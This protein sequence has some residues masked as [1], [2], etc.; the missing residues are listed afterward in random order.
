MSRF[1][2]TRNQ[3]GFTLIELL[4]VIAIIAILIG[5]LLP[6]IQKVRD[7][8][9]KAASSNNLKQMTLATVNY[10]D[11]ND[12]SLP[13]YTNQ[14]SIPIGTPPAATVQIFSAFYA[15]LP[16][17]DN[18][19][20]Y[21]QG[22]TTAS[23][24]P[25]RPYFAPGDPMADPRATPGR[26]SYIS[27]SMVLTAVDLVTVPNVS[28]ARF[29]ASITDGPSQTIAFLEAYAVTG[30]NI[31]AWADGAA[32]S[33]NYYAVFPSGQAAS[34]AYA[35]PYTGGGTGGAFFEVTPVHTSTQS[36]ASQGV[37]QGFLS[38]GSQVS[39]FDGS[40]RNCLPALSTSG[41]FAEALTPA[42]GV[43]LGSDW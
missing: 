20:L 13:G 27:N 22:V 7:A 4:V 16:Q 33:Y 31:R 39:L 35:M 15:I 30:T 8:A 18:D 32:T 19:P 28:P 37:S 41:T 21:K 9:N 40:A 2:R 5:M 14:Q 1:V 3:R 24:L 42:S 36:G 34:G 10:T 38:S 17:M 26:T 43:P 23:L 12:G 29:P 11:Q 6:A 25:Y